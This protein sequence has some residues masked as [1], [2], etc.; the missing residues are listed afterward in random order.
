MIY[1]KVIDAKRKMNPHT[2]GGLYVIYISN[3][4]INQNL[5]FIIRRSN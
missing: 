4:F 2:E 5:F 3:R 1:K